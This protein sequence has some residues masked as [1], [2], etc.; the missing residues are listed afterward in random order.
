M[1]SSSSDPVSET[2]PVV[3]DLS[4]IPE[5][6]IQKFREILLGDISQLPPEAAAI[7]RAMGIEPPADAI[8]S[9]A[10]RIKDLGLEKNVEELRDQG[11]TIVQ[12]AFDHEFADRLR[13]RILEAA[14][15]NRANGVTTM[16]G[17][18]GPTGRTV[19]RLLERGRVFE[20]AAL[21]PALVALMTSVLGQGYTV[22]T[23]S[24]MIRPEGTPRLA[25]H[26]D[27]QFTPDPFPE[28]QQFATAVWY[29]EDLTEAAGCSRVVPGSRKLARHPK[30]GEG[31]DRA[32]PLEAP[33]GSIVMWVGSTWHGSCA[34]VLPGERVT[35]HTAH[36]RMHI[37]P[38]ETY[39]NI[40]QEILDRNPP[41]FARL[42]GREA[43]YGYGVEGPDR[44]K[45]IKA[46]LN[47]HASH[48]GP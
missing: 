41:F 20:E 47:A 40:A 30:P 22:A 2:Q 27:N 33:K 23:Y 24:S 13:Q 12:N 43:P 25:L 11:Y 19:F 26:S 5:A 3:P 48:R 9:Q 18:K 42:I 17:D 32:I 4:A 46:H 45:L 7:L 6:A 36:C 10:K 21:N 44:L 38:L 37:R 35:L 8:E 1:S 16:G 31:E 15:E 28:W 39:E 29:L 34:R 14:D